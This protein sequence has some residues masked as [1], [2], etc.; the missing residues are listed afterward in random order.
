MNYLVVDESKKK[1]YT[2]LDKVQEL[3][4][5]INSS[6]L[7]LNQTLSAPEEKDRTWQILEK[8][9]EIMSKEIVKELHKLEKTYFSAESD[10]LREGKVR[11]VDQYRN[12]LKALNEKKSFIAEQRKKKSVPM[13]P[14]HQEDPQAGY[15]YSC[16]IDISNK[17]SYQLEKELKS[18]LQIK[19]AEG[20]KFCSKDCLSKYCEKYEE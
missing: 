6:L 7:V 15:C 9:G 4:E 12:L 3:E 8:K 1:L 5:E 18:V 14:F 11:L 17:F 20:A 2:Y 10:K 19:I 16:K 13:V